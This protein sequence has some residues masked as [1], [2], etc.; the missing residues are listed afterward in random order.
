ML[1]SLKQ[2]IY[3]L[4]HKKIS[5]IATLILLLLMV[6]TGY[7][8]G[9]EEAK[10]CLMTCYN[11]SYWITFI[12]IIVGATTFSM[13]FQNNTILTLLYKSSNKLKVY[14]AKFIVLS[15]YNIYLHAMAII[16]TFILS[17]SIFKS[18]ITWIT[19]YQYG[20]PIWQ[21]MLNTMIVDLL[22]TTLVLSIVFMLSCMVNN[23]AIVITA[24]VLVFFIG[25]NVSTDLLRIHKFIG[26]MKWNPFSMLNLTDQYYNYAGY[27]SITHLTNLEMMLG[28]ACYIALF[29]TI[30]YLIF[31]KK[32]F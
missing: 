17:M 23:N 15:L 25:G 4:K 14:I 29:L 9:Y 16:F 5:W 19:V 24:S 2:E 32:S 7:S 22:T 1:Y 30:S 21:N 26:V 11:A 6:I 18:N 8:I 31:R 3:K 20:Q 27:I 13:E 10:V 28:T 12:L